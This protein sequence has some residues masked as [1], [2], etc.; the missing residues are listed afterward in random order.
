M[1]YDASLKNRLKRAEGQLRG[2]LKM[3]EEERECREIIT[4]LSA[5]RSAIDKSMAYI[6]AT[7]LEKCIVDSQNAGSDSSEIV[8]EAIELLMKSR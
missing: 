6:V 2:I 7:N 4:Q 5:V 3:I 1:N 8:K